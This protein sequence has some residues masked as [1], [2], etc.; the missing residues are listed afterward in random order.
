MELRYYINTTQ[1]GEPIGFDDFKTILKRTGQHGVSAESS[2][3]ELEFDGVGFGIV[4]TAYNT[5][6]DTELIF[7]AEIKC[8]DNDTAWSELYSGILDL[9]TYQETY[10][11]YCGCR[12]K[13]G[14]IGVKTTFNNRVDTVVDL[15]SL[16]SLD[17]DVLSVY[18]NLRKNTL[19]TAKPFKYTTLMKSTLESSV[20]SKAITSSVGLTSSSCF[21]GVSIAELSGYAERSTPIQFSSFASSHNYQKLDSDLQ[22][23][24]ATGTAKFAVK[25]SVAITLSKCELRF[26]KSSAPTTI[27]AYYEFNKVHPNFT[28]YINY[29]V[30]F[31]VTATLALNEYF[32][33]VVRIETPSNLT[34][35][36]KWLPDSI[37]TLT[38]A[39][40]GVDSINPVYLLHETFSR[41]SEIISGVTVKS[42]LYSRANSNINPFYNE[43]CFLPSKDELALI[44]T[45]LYAFSVGVFN[46]VF[47]WSSSEINSTEVWSHNFAAN[48][49]R[50]DGKTSLVHYGALVCVKYTISGSQVYNLRDVGVN[51]GYIF[52]FVNNAGSYTYYEY[53]YDYTNIQWSNAT[54]LISGTQTAV[55]TG[56]ANTTLIANS[57]VNTSAYKVRTGCGEASLRGVATGEMLRNVVYKDGTDTKINLSF[58]ELF[59]NFN[60]VD[61]IGWG[62]SLENNQLYIRVER[63]NW[64]YND[65][66]IMSINSPANKK[67]NFNPEIINTNLNIGFD[68]FVSKDDFNAIE[69]FHTQREYSTKIKAI[70]NKLDSICKYIADPYAL[71]LTRKLS[72]VADTKDWKY[73]ENIFI[74]CFLMDRS[75]YAISLE[76]DNIS[77]SPARNAL[78]F[79]DKFFFSNFNATKNFFLSG[80]GHIASENTIFENVS[81]F[82]NKDNA[83][84][85]KYAENSDINAVN[86]FLK[87]ELISFE[88]PLTLAEYNDIKAEPYG[89]IVVDGE[90]CYIDEIVRE[91]MTGMCEFKLIPKF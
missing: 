20:L 27:I 44:R 63:K 87:P 80:S 59:K 36:I 50:Q 28:D 49:Q 17:G 42:N 82:Q 84:F 12:V 51:G 33:C 41:I 15:D 18:S 43:D 78:N 54:G 22:S 8:D 26:Y 37:L 73:D 32:V 62:F 46:A 71:E 47:F 40:L 85:V 6:I 67:R 72:A 58:K 9:S 83:K 2:V 60:A 21:D 3:G 1:I 39:K 25:T 7:K 35:S 64:F 11:D 77:I 79:N 10:D 76:N 5:D 4:Q 90:A 16:V 48:E 31:D 81:Y 88:Y 75:N 69:A 24:K 52:H 53:I 74:L 91:V 57:N 55:G 19:L 65:S 13:V 70:D 89:Q 30:D 61:N 34:V 45:N 23:L 56:L 29:S 68:K 38:S 86:S 66:I 14:E